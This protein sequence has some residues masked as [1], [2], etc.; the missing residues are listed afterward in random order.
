MT[1][2]SALP[3]RRQR[4]RLT[5]V[6]LIGAATLALSACGGTEKGT[7]SGQG[8]GAEDTAAQAKVLAKVPM[9]KV[10]ELTG[11]MG[12]WTTDKSFVK[13]DLKKLTGY[14]L[15]GGKAQ[16]EIPLTGEVCWSSQQP[17]EDGL[18]AVVFQNDKEDTPTCT[19]VGLVDLNKGKLVWTKQSKDEDGFT[20]D[21]SEVTISGGTVAAGGGSGTA[22]WSLDGKPLW[23][24]GY[25]DKC[26]DIGYAG[27]AEKMV[28]I[29]NC[30][31]TDAP[32][33]QVQTV[34]PRNR[35]AKSSL[36]L[37]QGT[38]Y[39]HVVSVDP[40]VVAVDDGNSGGGSGTSEF[41]SIDDSAAQGKVLGRISNKG[42]KYGKYES[43][44]APTTVNGCKQLAV[45][46]K[47]GTLYLPTIKPSGSEGEND[48]VAFD[49][50]TGQQTGRIAGA[51]EGQLLPIGLDDDGNVMAYQESDIMSESGGAVWQ[52]DPSV[53]KKT[54][55]LQNP[56]SSYE[57]ESRF[58]TDRRMLFANDRLYLGADHVSEP[59]TIYKT[60]QPLAV[61]FGT[62]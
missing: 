34:D 53:K 56:S 50:K 52:I 55:V 60:P 4:R 22:A 25:G 47:A 16:W 19:E 31:E 42:G 27:N 29:R 9:A 26:P 1:L 11:A 38:E 30:G 7:D 17:T 36:A 24:Q 23:S 15:A 59:S 3:A 33:L 13:T 57:M 37:P 32:K 48:I 28:A 44:C 54:K 45:S 35:T 62:K 51:D 61:V 39:A 6:A 49:L 5:G 14:P 58:E 12:M 8:G 20:A 41:L 21:F 2:R 10:S 18:I 46:K 43:E 40:L